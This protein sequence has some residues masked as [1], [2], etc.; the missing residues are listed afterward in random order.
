M[1]PTKNVEGIYDFVRN[2]IRAKCSDAEWQVFRHIASME[3][4]GCVVGLCMLSI[5]LF[6]ARQFN[7]S[8]GLH[9]FEH[10]SSIDSEFI[11]AGLAATGILLFLSGWVFEEL[12]Y[13][14]VVKPWLELI[15]HSFALLAGASV[16]IGIGHGLGATSVGAGFGLSIA[17]FVGGSFIAVFVSFLNIGA[18]PVQMSKNPG[19]IETLFGNKVSRVV[20]GLGSFLA[21]FFLRP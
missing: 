1:E 21:Y 13:L 15:A 6:A 12:A 8:V 9:F 5:H 4:S 14:Y 11:L 16:P 7:K 3:I 2:A 19:S 20:F 18:N 17:L 10:L